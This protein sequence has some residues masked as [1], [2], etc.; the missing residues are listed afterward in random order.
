MGGRGSKSRLTPSPVAPPG[1]G[2]R[3]PDPTPLITPET[4]PEDE[5]KKKKSSTLD[6]YLGPQGNPMNSVDA[7][8]GAN[9]HFMESVT[10]RDKK[11]T[12]NCQ[13]CVWATELRRRGYDVEAM[14]YTGEGEYARFDTSKPKSFLNVSKKKIDFTQ[15]G[16]LWGRAK[17]T[18]IKKLILA[19]PEGSRGMLVMMGLKSG[20][21]CNWEVKNGKAIVYDGQS[22][23]AHKLSDLTKHFYRFNVGRM[24][25]IPMSE[26]ADPLIRDFVK[27]SGT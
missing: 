2:V 3:P 22:N 9:P 1:R 10:K 20:H 21:V 16:S 25:D 26:L 12:H 6:E 13:R 7:A 15:T 27:R 8:K 11:Y 18:D 5:A 4:E 19:H 23:Q 14:A 17:A 24:D